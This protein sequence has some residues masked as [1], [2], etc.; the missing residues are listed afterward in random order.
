MPSL[1]VI[2]TSRPLCATMLILINAPVV[3]LNGGKSRV[4]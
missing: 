2:W 4:G 3:M 1:A